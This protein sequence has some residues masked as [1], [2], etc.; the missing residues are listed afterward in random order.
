MDPLNIIINDE[1]KVELMKAISGL[2]EFQRLCLR[3]VELEG[4]SIREVAVI[5][6][7]TD[8]RVE[9]AVKN[10]KHILR[11]FLGEPSY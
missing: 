10:A 6:R 7:S 5:N 4:L 1:N 9:Y 3:L 2:G 8:S 11:G